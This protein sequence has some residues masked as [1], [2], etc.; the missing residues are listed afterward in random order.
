MMTVLYCAIQPGRGLMP[1]VRDRNVSGLSY[2]RINARCQYSILPCRS[3]RDG[4]S[5]G[6]GGSERDCRA[7]VSTQQVGR[8]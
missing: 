7:T 2:W 6:G 5:V 3:A 8:A 1:A 4:R